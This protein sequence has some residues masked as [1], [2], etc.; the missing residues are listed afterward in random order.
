MTHTVSLPLL[1]MF[2]FKPAND[3]KQILWWW[4]QIQCYGLRMMVKTGLVFLHYREHQ[5]HICSTSSTHEN[6]FE[7]E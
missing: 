1:L 3:E 6:K 5:S 4:S 2:T 7:F